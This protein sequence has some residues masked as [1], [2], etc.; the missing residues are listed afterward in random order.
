MT[1]KEV[2]GFEYDEEEVKGVCPDD[3]GPI[4][5]APIYVH[6]LSLS[7]DEREAFDVGIWGVGYCPKVKHFVQWQLPDFEA[8]PNASEENPLGQNIIYPLDKFGRE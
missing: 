7:N 1:I 5:D 6:R 8:R 4:I 3:G 2:E